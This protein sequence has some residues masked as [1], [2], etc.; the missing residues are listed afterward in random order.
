[1]ATD[2]P[3]V[4]RSAAE[5]CLL[6]PSESRGSGRTAAEVKVTESHQAFC[7]SRVSFLD[8]IWKHRGR[9][10]ERAVCHR[11]GYLRRI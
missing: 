2:V 8:L 6:G 5:V 9:E 3:T 4:I 11:H 1:M 10:R 7:T